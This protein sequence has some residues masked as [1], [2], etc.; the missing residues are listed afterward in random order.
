MKFLWTTALCTGL[1][2]AIA[3]PLAAAMEKTVS[4]VEVTVDLSAYEDNNVLKYWPTLEDDLT[5]AIASKLIV[6]NAVN[7][8]R[9]AVAIN[10]VAIDGDTNLPDSG[11]FNQLIGTITTHGGTNS[12][13]SSG[14]GDSSHGHIGSYALQMTAISGETELAEGWI[15]V[16]PSQDDFYNALIDAYASRIVERMDE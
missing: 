2:L 3:G 9:I 14:E 15:A 11:E 4:G 5:V 10:K 13:T 16:E 1:T 6:D 7:A 8:P 12:A